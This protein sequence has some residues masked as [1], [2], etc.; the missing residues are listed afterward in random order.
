M[1]RRFEYNVSNKKVVCIIKQEYKIH[2]N[3][4]STQVKLFTY[5]ELILNE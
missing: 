1:F 4:R 5:L 2:L 3:N